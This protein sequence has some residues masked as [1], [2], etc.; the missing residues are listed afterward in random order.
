ML[1]LTRRPGEEIL[2]GEDIKVTLLNIL[3]ESKTR[4]GIEAP[5]HIEILRPD[6]KCKFPSQSSTRASSPRY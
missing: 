3:G 6:A 4:I 5:P 1:I 2:I